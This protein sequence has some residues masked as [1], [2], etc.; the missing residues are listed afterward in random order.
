MVRKAIIAAQARIQA[1]ELRKKLTVPKGIGGLPGK[2]RDCTSRTPEGCEIYL[3]EGDSAG[4]SAEGGRERKFQAILPLRG[5]IINAFKYTAEKVLANNEVQSIIQALGTQVGERF[6]IEKLRYHK[7][8]IM[9]DADVDGSH[10]RT[11]LLSFFYRQMPQL[12]S[13][14]HVYIAQPPLYRIRSRKTNDYVQSDEEMKQRLLKRGLNGTKL[15]LESGIEFGANIVA[16]AIELSAHYLQLKTRLRKLGLQIES[17]AQALPPNERQSFDLISDA[18][19]EL[20]LSL[21]DYGPDPRTGA[22]TPR[23]VVLHQGREYPLARLTELNDVART[24]GELGIQITRFKGLGEMNA[25]ELRV[26]TL[27]PENRNLIRVTM[28]DAARASQMFH[29]LMGVS[30]EPRREFIETHALD[31]RNLDI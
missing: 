17:N 4:G 13:E 15:R 28:S 8:I 7:V 27:L 30:V 11:L 21:T 26:T 10:I 3:V 24:I 29:L 31:V 12:I 23:F 5:K 1:K 16:A 9:S 2:L 14:G 22:E 25:E 19:E 20:G 18:A 6:E